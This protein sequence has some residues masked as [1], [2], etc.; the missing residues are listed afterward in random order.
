MRR[1]VPSLLA[2]G[3]AAALCPVAHAAD[4]T[5]PALKAPAAPVSTWTGFYAGVSLGGRWSDA[6]WRTTGV[7]FPVGVGF[8]S[9]PD[10]STALSPFDASTFRAGIYYGYNW[11][12]G[13]SVLVGIESDLAWGNGRKTISGIPGT[14]GA[15]LGRANLAV[16]DST[17]VREGFDGSSRLRAGYLFTPNLLGYLTAG[18]AAQAITVGATCSV[19]GPWCFA[20]RSQS[21]SRTKVGWTVG[22]GVETRLSANWLARAEYRYADFG[23]VSS[24]LFATSDSVTYD[25]RLRTHTA[26]VGLGYQFNRSIAESIAGSIETSAVAPAAVYKAPSAALAPSWSGAY[27]GASLGGRWSS[28]RWTTTAIEFGGGIGGGAS[29]I[30]DPSTATPALD[31]ATARA[32]GYAGYLWQ[33]S[34]HWVVGTEGDLAWGN[35]RNA[36]AGVPGTFGTILGGIATSGFDSTSVK[37]GWDASLLTRIGYLVTPKVMIYGTG[38]AALQQISATVNCT[39]AA[40]WCGFDAANRLETH[41]RIKPGWTLGAGV[42]AALSGNWRVRGEY[43]YADFG[44]MHQAFFANSVDAISAD[45]RVR[46]QTALVGLSYA[47]AGPLP[48]AT[49]Y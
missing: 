48:L 6:D 9:V 23:T 21:D 46:T 34:R 41:S 2:A 15:V 36:V 22:G 3:F 14:Y 37:Q 28:T 5:G 25:L 7:A 35:S 10:P 11:Q 13:P 20:D 30:P 32:G 42:E 8:S 18:V 31:S 47:F 44:T 12:I 1:T 26:M 40:I 4:V 43:R 27:A 33:V 38:G 24:A 17:Q 39:A 16:L 19:A 49:G 29:E 45:I